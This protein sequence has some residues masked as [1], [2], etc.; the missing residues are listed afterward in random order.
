MTI[1]ELQEQAHATAKEKGWHDKPR[2]FADF[3]AN[4]HAELSEAWEDYR[5]GLPVNDR[6]VTASGKPIGIPIELADIFIRIAEYAYANDIDLTVA[7]EAK[8]RYNA[9]REYRHGNKLA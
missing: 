9:T 1:R 8:M 7:L 3:I 5:N 2:D 6:D 4:V